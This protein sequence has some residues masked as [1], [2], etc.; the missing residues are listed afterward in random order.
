[1]TPRPT[2]SSE[3]QAAGMTIDS[4]SASNMRH[5][6]NGVQKIIDAAIGAQIAGVDK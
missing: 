4:I 6:V 3:L 5:V 1:M 2:D